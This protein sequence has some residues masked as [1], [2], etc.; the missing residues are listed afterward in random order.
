[1][2]AD[3]AAAALSSR[4]KILQ[5]EWLHQPDEAASRQPGPTI[6][7]SSSDVIFI[8]SSEESGGE[9]LDHERAG[10]PHAEAPDQYVS[11]R[12]QRDANQLEQAGRTAARE[13][14]KDAEESVAAAEEE[15]EEEEMEEVEAAPPQLP[16]RRPE[17]A[18]VTS[19]RA[20]AQPV[21]PGNGN[22]RP[23][24]RYYCPHASVVQDVACCQF[25]DRYYLCS[26]STDKCCRVHDLG[27]G[28]ALRTA[29]E[30]P[31]SLAAL[32]ISDSG[33]VYVGDDEGAIRCFPLTCTAPCE[34]FLSL[35]SSV[36]RV[37]IASGMLFVG[38]QSGDVS[39]YGLGCPI[40]LANFRFHRKPISGLQASTW[41][42]TNPSPLPRPPGP[43]CPSTFVVLH[44]N[45]CLPCTSGIS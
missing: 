21:L 18:H 37:H 34:L 2:Q 28:R 22:P 25:E 35:A 3:I 27:T 17:Q 16:H 15:E 29:I 30:G 45:A 19:T 39:I 1:M 13:K 23:Q 24:L 14:N 10:D 44:A 40:A 20:P 38:L 41:A 31:S 11:F 36:T 12:K 32:A 6:T 5:E 26:V 4:T 9:E 33:L 8:A 42:G 7:T 43:P